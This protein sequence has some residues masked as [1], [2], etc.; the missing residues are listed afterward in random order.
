MDSYPLLFEPITLNQLELRNRIVVPAMHLNCTPGGAVSDQLV[1]FYRE[2]AAGGAGLMIVGGCV[3]NEKA[4]G[5][6]FVSLMKDEDIP[7]FER[8][9]S[10]GHEHGAKVGAQ[11]YMAG[12]YS[13]AM[14]IGGEAIS[15]S[16]HTSRYTKEDCRAMSL[17][18]IDQVQDDF[19][20]AARRAQE[21][22]L[23]MVEILGSAGYLI[24]QF[25]SPAIN[26]REDEY[27]GSVENRMRFGLE[28]IAKVRAAVGGD[29]CV[30]IR[31]AGNDFVPGSHTNEEAAMFARACEEAG[32]D[33]INVTGGWHETRVPQITQELPPGGFSYLARGVKWAVDK[34]PVAAS[35]RIHSPD[36]AEG[37]LA[38]GDADLVCLGR[39]MLADPELPM[40]AQAGLSKLIRRCVAC[41]QGCFDAI[42]QMKPVGCMV[43]PRA[44][45]E[46]KDPGPEP[47]AAPKKV[48]V[49]GGGPAGCQ[50]AITAAGRGHRV[51]LMEK[52]ESLGGQ[53]AWWNEPLM[54]NDFGS[55]P[56]WQAA[57]LEDL[58]V[59]VQLGAEATAETVAGLGPDAV[60]LAT[61]SAP[62]RPPIPGADGERVF[63]AW[64]VI[65]GQ[66]LC[67]GRVVV[68][69][70]GAVGLE[71]ALYVARQGALTPEQTYFIELFGAETPEVT[72]RLVAQ[73]SHPVTVLEALP[74]IGAGIGRSTRWITF[75]LIKRFGVT[76][77]TKVEVKAIGQGTV[78][79]VIDGQEQELQADTVILATGTKPQD[80]LA[81]ELEARGIEVLAVGDAG[82][83]ADALAAIRSGYKAGAG[84]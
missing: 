84:L 60:V 66:A 29:F 24:C 33:L 80:G 31:I 70:G 55:I 67:Q 3:I 32:V 68:I 21:A 20:A 6:I 28:T 65:S 39:P 61:G 13:H 76:V 11:L 35:N 74:K 38:R 17:E 48:V 46:A 75:G 47:A 16:A 54:K 25:L 41:N 50:A 82:G 1:A 36:L 12:A 15:A 8:L 62:A 10:A 73:G 51:V 40:K 52:A 19:A 44:G 49:I 45:R 43:N 26:Q 30:G 77:H 56:A 22:G 64:E 9:A 27:G 72:A 69:G 42:P 34:V 59:E 23:D 81:A 37:I 57:T 83:G 53:I 7:G 14:L 5:P 63:T 79:A 78:T 71:T 4:G 18:E 2:R 58:E